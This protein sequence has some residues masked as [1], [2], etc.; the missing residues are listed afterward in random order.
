MK[1]I[2]VTGGKGGTGKSTFAMLLALGMSKGG[3]VVLCDCDVE[4]PNDHIVLDKKLVRPEK[5]KSERPKLEESKCTKCG[6]CSEVCR[7]GAVFY[8]KDSYPKFIHEL[9]SGCGACWLA[10][11]SGAIATE[12]VEMGSTFASKVNKNLWL[13]T[14]MTNP[15]VEE[16]VP[17]VKAAKQR[18]LKLANKVKAE[19]LVIDTAAGTHCNVIQALY[20][21]DVAYAVTEPTPVG[22]HDLELILELLAIIEIEPM[23]V[24]N[25]SDIGNKKPVGKLAKKFGVEIALEI[26]HSERLFKAYAGCRLQEFEPAYMEGLKL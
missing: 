25:R 10:C 15:G 24:I 4:C 14:G 12:D 23:I 17:V 11:P 5:V 8:V 22:L 9:C 20:G 7:N 21:S 13:V 1:I 18:A 16:A 2:G 3:K 26:P 6:K 19:Y